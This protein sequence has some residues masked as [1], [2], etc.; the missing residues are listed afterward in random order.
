MASD[1]YRIVQQPGQYVVIKP[2]VLHW[3]CN[4]GDNTAEA[5]NFALANH[6]EELQPEKDNYQFFYC[7]SDRRGTRVR[8]CKDRCPTGFK[9]WAAEIYLNDAGSLG[10]YQQGQ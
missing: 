7:K 1:V 10:E 8:R 9:T 4:C 5:I 6:I 3:G 2:G